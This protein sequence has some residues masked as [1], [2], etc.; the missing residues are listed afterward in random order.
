M[1]KKLTR[2][3]KNRILAGVCGGIADYLGIDV[4]WVRLILII[5]TPLTYFLTVIAYI[6]AIFLIPETRNIQ[7]TDGS[8][9]DVT[10]SV[11]VS[12]EEKK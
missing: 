5:L 9:K 10:N 2:S 12:D 4:V 6:V 8:R 7:I 3:S 1:K 11:K